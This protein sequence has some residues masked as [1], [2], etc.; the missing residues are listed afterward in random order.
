[1]SEYWLTIV[2]VLLI[3]AIVIDGIR[4]MRNARRD[5]LKMALRPVSRGD[6]SS[7]DDGNYGSEFPSGGARPSDRRIDPE[8]IQQ[9]RNKYNFGKDMNAWKNKVADKIAEHTGH[10]EDQE[11]LPEHE[12]IEPSMV[13]FD[14]LLDEMPE[15]RAYQASSASETETEIEDELAVEEPIAPPTKVAPPPASKSE[16][17]QASLNLDE[18]V[19]MLMDSLVDDN[20]QATEAPSTSDTPEE[21]KAEPIVAVGARMQSSPKA[22]QTTHSANK[23]RY[24]SKYADHQQ[25]QAATS[26]KDVLVIHVRAQENEY[27]Y[28]DDLL[29]LILDNG[30][31]FGAMDIFHCHAGEDGEGPVL[32]SMANMVKPGSFDLHSFEELSTVGVSFFLI[33]PTETESNMQAFERMLSTATRIAEKLHGELQDENRSVLTKQTMEHYRERI[34][35]FSRRQQL[36][37]NK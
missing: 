2:I 19:P 14:P 10:K 12:R 35:D 1:M 8:R 33:L 30:L 16:P 27:F 5:S 7:S 22:Q 25:Q 24:E 37:K 29:E 15:R 6:N 11:S 23:P 13:D 9:V 4:R 34:R 17:V 20:D 32:F 26:P 36:E 21:P 18:T 31:R 3:I 28:G